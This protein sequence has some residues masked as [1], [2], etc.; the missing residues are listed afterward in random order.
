MADAILLEL[1][2]Q[3]LQATRM[4]ELNKQ[5]IEPHSLHMWVCA[6]CK[7]QNYMNAPRCSACYTS[8]C[9]LSDELKLL[10]RDAEKATQTINN[11]YTQLIQSIHKHKAKMLNSIASLSKSMEQRIIQHYADNTNIKHTKQIHNTF[12]VSVDNDSTF[13]QLLYD[14]SLYTCALPSTPAVD[15]EYCYATSITFKVSSQN[16]DSLDDESL[17][18]E[19]CDFISSIIE[20]TTSYITGCKIRYAEH[21]SH[22]DINELNPRDMNWNVQC[23]GTSK[24][25]ELDELTPS[26][27]YIVSVCIRN[28]CG[29]SEWSKPVLYKTAMSARNVA[30][31]LAKDPDTRADGFR[32]DEMTTGD[33]VDVLDKHGGWYMAEILDTDEAKGLKVHFTNWKDRYDEWI[34][35]EEQ[36]RM[37]PLND[38]ILECHSLQSCP[39]HVISAPMHYVM[40]HKDYVVMLCQNVGIVTYD[41]EN[42]TYD[43]LCSE[44]IIQN[45]DRDFVRTSLDTNRNILYLMFA[46]DNIKSYD[47]E[48]A[49]WIH[50]GIVDDDGQDSE[51]ESEKMLL[52]CFVSELSSYHLVVHFDGYGALKM[53]KYDGDG[54]TDEMDLMQ[55]DVMP[56]NMIYCMALNKIIF[57]NDSPQHG[58]KS[59]KRS[60]YK[61][62]ALTLNANECENALEAL[63]VQ[64][65][66][67]TEKCYVLAFDQLLFIILSGFAPPIYC[68]DM[69]NNMLYDTNKKLPTI[70]MGVRSQFSYGVRVR[71][72]IHLFDAGYCHHIAFSIYDVLPKELYSMYSKESRVLLV[73]GYCKRMEIQFECVI[74][75]HLQLLVLNFYPQYA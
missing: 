24:S 52:T 58:C 23:F 71:D 17:D 13:K 1:K 44:E 34:V 40:N 28:D 73:F 57:V 62:Y 26:T 22:D 36:Y 70:E 41:V 43:V 38:Y 18:T 37:A 69:Q 27:P 21:H 14:C 53:I 11:K 3:R 5:Q 6:R 64:M 39:D 2:K 10:Y 48:R 74:P 20:N 59:D 68:Y 60:I 49:Q 30:V 16:Q 19:T 7:L 12:E 66:K 8:R 25:Y 46:L 61:W 35:R 50:K 47:I 54:M 15:R 75:R 56:S 55:P 42:N 33:A 72:Y 63:E 4:A 29:W 65:T 31:T 51:F 67:H 9:N 32:F 45:D